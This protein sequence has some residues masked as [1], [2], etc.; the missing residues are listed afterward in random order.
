MLF[1]GCNN[2]SNKY[3]EISK[4]YI[5]LNVKADS[6]KKDYDN[7]L[8][9]NNDI[10]QKFDSQLIEYTELQK[11]YFGLYSETADWRLL[12]D[13]QKTERLANAEIKRDEVEAQLNKINK[14]REDKE[15]ADKAAAEAERI[16]AER[17]K[18][19]T[20]ITYDQL[21]RNPDTYNNKYVTFT[22]RVLQVIEDGDYVSLLIYTRYNSKYNS[23]S[24]DLII[25]LYKKSI[26]SSRILED[27]IVS[28]YGISQ[29][30]HKYE[31][32]SGSLNTIPYILVDIIAL[33]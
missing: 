30:L 14:E 18:Y 21:A 27:D 7:L 10:I 3:N 19:N 1:I 9:N 4:L 13:I 31:Q 22:G 25:V 17:N 12:T 26:I 23:Y 33:H 8:L 6:L 5:E 28:I 32:V 15:N 11:K 2:T 24:D 16:K 20:G 29:G